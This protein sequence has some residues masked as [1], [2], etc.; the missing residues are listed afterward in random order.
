MHAAAARTESSEVP[1]HARTLPDRDDE[2]WMK[3]TSRFH[4]HKTGKT[5]IKYQP[6]HCGYRSTKNRLVVAPF[7]RVY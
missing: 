6:V 3:H 2:N 4:D 1:T 5:E 7:A